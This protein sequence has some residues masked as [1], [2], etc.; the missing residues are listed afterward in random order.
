MLA[1]IFAVLTVGPFFAPAE[2]QAKSFELSS[3]KVVADVQPNGSVVVTENITYDFTGSF[4][5]GYRE[6]PLKDGMSVSDVSVSE[7]GKQYAP[8]AATKLGSSGVPGTYGTA[9]LG[10]AYRIV[11][12]YGPP[13][14]SAHSPSAT[15]S[16]AWPWPTTTWWTSTGR[17]GAMSGKSLWA[18]SGRP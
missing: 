16:A 15:A 5:G 18:R 17:P 7:N 3:A 9:N 12:H 6:I 11:W 8:G 14:R 13:T 2:A 1:L 4:E 10:D